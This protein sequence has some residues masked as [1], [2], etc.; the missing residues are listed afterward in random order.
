M[1]NRLLNNRELQQEIVNIK[2][3]KKGYITNLFLEQ[4]KIERLIEQK[5]LEIETGNEFVLI[6][7]RNTGFTNV[8]YAASSKEAMSSR[9]VELGKEEEL[10]VLDIIGKDPEIITD[11]DFFEQNHFHKYTH[12]NRMNILKGNEDNDISFTTDIHVQMAQISEAANIERELKKHFD[13]VAEQLPEKEDVIS[14]IENGGLYLYKENEEIL[15]IVIFEINGTTSFLRYWFVNPLHR[16]KKI[17]SKLLNQFFYRSRE[18]KRLLFW[19]IGSNTNAIER[20][21]HF[22]FK[23]ENLYNYVITNKRIK[24]E[25]GNH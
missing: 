25:T 24:H 7:R 22:G 14:W 19:V 13:A 5:K 6:F 8:Y 1:R 4:G 2:T 17:G 20:Y 21:K 11:I 15:G 18:C 10:Y 23:S 12:L 9:L 16:D 3:L